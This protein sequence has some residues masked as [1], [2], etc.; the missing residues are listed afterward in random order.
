MNLNP[1]V[2]NLPKS[3]CTLG[4]ILSHPSPKKI[5]K[6]I[7]SILN[8]VKFPRE[9]WMPSPRRA[10]LGD[11]LL[12]L[13]QRLFERWRLQRRRGKTAFN[14]SAGQRIYISYRVTNS[15]WSMP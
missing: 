7:K 1:K 12:Q 3:P 10:N 9:Q 15:E 2:F 13:G 6:N 8:G 14:P 5:L 4:W 11:E